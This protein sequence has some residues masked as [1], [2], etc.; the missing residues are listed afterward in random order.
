MWVYVERRFQVEAFKCISKPLNVERRMIFHYKNVYEMQNLE[1][2]FF[3]SH[4]ACQN[5]SL[6]YK[7]WSRIILHAYW[8]YVGL[9]RVQQ[10]QEVGTHTQ[11]Q[12]TS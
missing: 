7:G 12:K 5:S 9:L 10:N 3:W 11:T 2:T 6:T 8:K 1:K 4:A